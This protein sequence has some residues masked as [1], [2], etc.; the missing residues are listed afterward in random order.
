MSS[1]PQAIIDRKPVTARTSAIA[2]TTARCAAIAVAIGAVSSPPL[3]NAAA[4]V[5]LLSFVCVADWRERASRVLREPLGRGVAI[6]AAALLLAAVIGALGPAGIDGAAQALWNWRPLLLLLFA[7]AVFDEPHWRFR[8]AT[9]FVV[10]AVVAAVVALIFLQLGLA[11]RIDHPPGI[12]LRNHAT[13][14]MTFAAGVFLAAMLWFNRMAA[15]RWL[16]AGLGGAALGLLAVLPL[17]QTGR[18][19]WLML[20][21]AAVTAVALTLRGRRLALG[22]LLVPVVA[23][24]VVGASPRIQERFRVGWQEATGVATGSE[25]TSMGIRVVMWRTTADLIGDRPVAGYGLGGYAPAYAA[26]IKQRHSD[27]KATTTPDAHNQY[28]TLW[29]EAGLAGLL[30]FAWFLFSALRQE[31]QPPWRAIG[32]SLLAGWCAT[33]MLSSHFQTFNE[34]HLIAIFLGAFLARPAYSFNARVASGC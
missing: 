21:V 10:F 6:F 19:G 18:S 12:V 29:V 26:L 14:S 15:Q 23:A 13:Q 25:L 3:A 17:T 34:G 27:W 2:L 8:F 11:H 16:H 4:L 7:L 22:L 9:G 1:D 31:A 32:V 5:M 20:I 28:L 24:A 33:S 30:A